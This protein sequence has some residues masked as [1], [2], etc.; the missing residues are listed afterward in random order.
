MLG[1]W[2]GPGHQ[3]DPAMNRGLEFSPLAPHS[4]E[5]GEGLEMEVITDLACVRKPHVV[6][7]TDRS[8]LRGG[9]GRGQGRCGRVE[10]AFLTMFYLY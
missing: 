4:P 10:W 5:R 2:V 3:K 8:G 6:K 7:E 1:S 9:G